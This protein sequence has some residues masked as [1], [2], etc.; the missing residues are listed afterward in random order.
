[1][2]DIESE[3]LNYKLEEEPISNPKDEKREKLKMLCVE[4][5]IDDSDNI[6]FFSR[7]LKK[8]K[9]NSILKYKKIEEVKEIARGLG[10]RSEN[11]IRIQIENE[12][13]DT[14]LDFLREEFDL[15]RDR[16]EK[17]NKEN[18]EKKEKNKK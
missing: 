18:K 1:M 3:I 17:E 7:D 15:R 11:E 9:I 10:I 12:I 8:I 14:I 13:K 2:K 6:T 5:G 4:F 16:Y